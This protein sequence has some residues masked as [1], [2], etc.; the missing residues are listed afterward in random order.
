MEGWPLASDVPA[1]HQHP[2]CSAKSHF[3][4]ST[5]CSCCFLLGIHRLLTNTQT[6]FMYLALG[7]QRHTGSSPSPVTCQYPTILPTAAP[8]Q[9]H[10]SCQVAPC[11]PT[12][13]VRNWA[14]VSLTPSS[15][16]LTATNA[17]SS[18]HLPLTPFSSYLCT[19]TTAQATAPPT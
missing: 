15:F 3:P 1:P 19:I 7:I 2:W 14:P 9:V 12:C 4:A 8:L 18:A 16:T 13:S 5:L 11:P 10:T 6:P 17:L